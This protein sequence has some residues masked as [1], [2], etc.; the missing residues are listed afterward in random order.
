MK[1]LKKVIIVAFV[2]HPHVRNFSDIIATV[3]TLGAKAN[4]WGDLG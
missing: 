1:S 4:L 2:K 3:V